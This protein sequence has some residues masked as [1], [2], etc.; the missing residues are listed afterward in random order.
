MKAW[1]RRKSLKAISAL[2]PM[3][4][5]I[6]NKVSAK[7]TWPQHPITL[8]V[9]YPP[10]GGSDTMARLIASKMG[11]M[12]NGNIVIVNRPGAA[13]TIAASSVARA[14]PDGYS[15]LIDASSFAI[16]LSLDLKLPYNAQSFSPVGL[17]ALFPLVLVVFPG[18][19]ANSVADL[20]NTAK[21]KPDTVFYASA[22]N[23]TIQQMVGIELIKSAKI[24]MTHVPYNGAG[25]ALNAVM[26]GQVQMFFANAAAAVPLVKAGKLRALAVTGNR[27]LSALPNTPTMAETVAGPLNSR[28]WIAMFAP[29]STPPD[30]LGRLSEALQKT[31]QDTEI[32][33][34]ISELSGETFSGSRNQSI[35]FINE[36]IK[37]MNRIVH[38]DANIQE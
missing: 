9:G 30:V 17:L 26:S 29:A 31:L 3:A 37:T 36:E 5:G 14:Q 34:R 19:D 18:F 8:T 33:S 6:I 27:R 35:R 25:P 2:A 16:N 20:I 38:A 7:A 28:E 13:G 21:A 1:T 12:L 4:F 32:K 22:G 24:G 15:L 11:P 23:G 10:G